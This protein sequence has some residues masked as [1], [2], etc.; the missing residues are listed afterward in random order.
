MDKVH[1][2][3]GPRKDYAHTFSSREADGVRL[4]ALVMGAPR[5]LRLTGDVAALDSLCVH[6]LARRVRG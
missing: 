6:E 5:G 3:R 2:K 4:D 1:P